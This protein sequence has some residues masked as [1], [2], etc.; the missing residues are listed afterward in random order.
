MV[1]LSLYELGVV[2]SECC[3]SVAMERRAALISVQSGS[4]GGVEDRYPFFMAIL[5]QVHEQ[6]RCG[7]SSKRRLSG[8]WTLRQPTLMQ[9]VERYGSYSE[10]GDVT[11]MTG[12]VSGKRMLR[13]ELRSS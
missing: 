7:L 12:S 10:G 6:Q 8:W 13:A 2:G 5:E 4:Q 3:M 1:W 11:A 9:K